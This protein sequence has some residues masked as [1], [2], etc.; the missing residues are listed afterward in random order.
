M[1][2][3]CEILL[4]M[5]AIFLPLGAQEAKNAPDSANNERTILHMTETQQLQV[6]SKIKDFKIIQ[7]QFAQLIILIKQS[8]GWGD[9]V[10]YDAETNNFYRLNKKTAEKPAK[11]KPPE[12]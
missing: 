6:E 8:N 11:E 4:V 10:V 2:Y 7:L 1:L 3:K 9:D 12:K 5:M